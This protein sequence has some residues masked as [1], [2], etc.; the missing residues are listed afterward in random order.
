MKLQ[1]DYTPP[2][3]PAFIDHSQKITLIGSC[4]AEEMGRFL[5]DHQFNCLVNPNGILFNPM[6]IAFALE[7]Y[8]A[9]QYPEKDLIKSE[10]LFRNLHYHGKLSH[11][12]ENVLRNE[13]AASCHEAHEHLKNSHWLLITF[14]S[15]YVYRHLK[16]GQIVANCH[17]LPQ[18]EFRKELLSVEEVVDR[19]TALFSSLNDLAPRLRIVLSVSPVKYI[20]DGLVENNLSKSILIQ[21][22]HELVKRH[23]CCSYFPAFELVNDVL[24]DHRFYAEDLAHPN[25]QAIRYA[26]NQFSESAFS[27]AT[28]NLNK[29]IRSILNDASHK[30][31]HPGT[32][33]HRAFQEAFLGKCESLEK[34]F[35]FL[36]FG[37]LK[38]RN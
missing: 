17:K 15:A 2:V 23:S 33:Q 19:Y 32:E 25:E 37:K 5:T 31:L 18:A 11:P 10:G 8:I 9:D 1:L 21:S 16:S 38:I 4:F 35:P 6:S 27:D 12:D 36:N 26:W 22:V 29:R 7:S 20:K 30:A 13:L 28:K 24:R 3:L 14:G 34:E